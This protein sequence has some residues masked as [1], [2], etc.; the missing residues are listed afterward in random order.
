MPNMQ[1]PGTL[2]IP[3]GPAKK[4]PKILPN[5]A[6]FAGLGKSAKIA[7]NCP[8]LPA[9]GAGLGPKIGQQSQKM[10]SSGQKAA[11]SEAPEQGLQ[12]GMKK[13]APGGVTML[14]FVNTIVL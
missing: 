9:L 3:P 2:R 4:C 12:K 13:P 7:K 1:T 14:T 5:S 8:K 10:P 11:K 6:K